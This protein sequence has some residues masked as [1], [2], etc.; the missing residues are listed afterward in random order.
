MKLT[1]TSKGNYCRDFYFDLGREVK[2]EQ[3]LNVSFYFREGGVNWY[4]SQNEKEG[5]C[6]S[7]TPVT[8]ENK[9]SYFVTKT[10]PHKGLKMF[11][12]EVTEKSAKSFERA[13]KELEWTD[14]VNLCMYFDDEM[15]I[16]EIEFMYNEIQKS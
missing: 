16:E 5:Y 4:T 3:E 2:D 6:I 7:L 15:K 1:R 11:L 10:S 9:G 12:K 14:F 13:V 8:V